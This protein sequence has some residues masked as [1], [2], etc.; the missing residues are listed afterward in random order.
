M[1]H[2]K[3]TFK[4]GR[5]G[6]HNRCMLANMLKSLVEH[7]RI[8]TTV[9]KAKELRRHADRL[10][11]LA[12]KNT[13]ATR[14]KAIAEMMI[15]FNPLTSKEARELKQDPT[16]TSACNGDRKVVGKLFTEL[17]ARFATRNGGYTRIIRKGQR[18]GDNAST[19]YI[20]YLAS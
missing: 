14:R 11:T 2:R 18:V 8:E 12:K 10:I 3:H 9:V 5:T 1:R 4:I 6:S 20:E 13:L 19:C 17:A 15:R 16:N 7:E